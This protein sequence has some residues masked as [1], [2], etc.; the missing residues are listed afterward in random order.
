MVWYFYTMIFWF[1][2]NLFNIRKDEVPF[3]L[4]R[5]T[6]YLQGFRTRFPAKRSSAFK[7]EQ[8]YW[9]SNEVKHESEYGNIVAR[10]SQEKNL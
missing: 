8:A 10:A 6:H 3:L 5:K 9:L 2:Q 4:A 1:K 7:H